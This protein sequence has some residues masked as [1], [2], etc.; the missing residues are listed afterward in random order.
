MD[1]N[2]PDI[3]QDVQT[4]VNHL[5]QRED[6]RI[7]VVRQTLK[8]AIHGVKS[9][10]CKGSGNLPDVMRLMDVLIHKSVMKA[11]VDPVDQH[12]SEKEEGQHTNNE[13]KP[14]TRKAADV[15]VQ[16]AVAAQLQQEQHDGGN[17]HPRQCPHREHDLSIDLVL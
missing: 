15:V 11:S 7:D 14:A 17:A 4:Q 10:A 9:M 3:D 2:C 5:V 16:L 12:V 8:E 13:L 1:G 6:E